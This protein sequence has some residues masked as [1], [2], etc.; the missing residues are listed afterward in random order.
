M[1]TRVTF[2]HWYIIVEHYSMK[3]SA[4]SYLTPFFYIIGTHEETF[5]INQNIQEATSSIILNYQITLVKNN[6]HFI[7]KLLIHLIQSFISYPFTS[8]CL[9]S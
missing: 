5:T 2:H 7:K 1:I 6:N 3:L 9:T 4:T 8:L